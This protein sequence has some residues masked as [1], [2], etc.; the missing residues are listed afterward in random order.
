MTPC[1]LCPTKN[2]CVRPDGNPKSDLYFIGE[3]P[4]YDENKKGIPF[5]GKTGLEVHNTYLPC[6]GL[7][8][9][10]IYIDNAI[11]CLPDR[12]KGKLDMN[13]K[14]DRELAETCAAHHLYPALKWN[15]PKIIVPMGAFACYVI[16]PDI[17]LE[18]HH[19]IPVQTRFGTAFPMYHPAGGIHEPKK[20]LQIRTDWI[21]L[22]RFLAGQLEI[23]VDEH[24]DPDYKEATA[25]D[26]RGIDPTLPMGSDTESSR[27][28][29]PYCITYSQIPGVGRLIRAE[30]TLHLRMFQQKIKKWE[31]IVLFHNWLYDKA[32]TEDMGLSFPDHVIK[33]TMVRAFHLGNLPQGLKALAYRYLGMEMQAFEDLVKPHSTK[34]VLEYYRNAYAEE[35][36]KPDPEL[37]QDEKTGLWK[38]YQP[39]SMKTKLKRFFTDYTKNPNKNVFEMWTKNWVNSQKIIEDRMGLWPGM[40]IRHV[41]FSEALHYA[42]RDSDATLRLWPLL[43]RMKENVKGRQQENW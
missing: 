10:E 3:A 28:L 13:R 38:L 25:A 22:R 20:M 18:M 19:G 40:D 39:Q 24:P 30:N 12:P 16:D 42:C 17:D 33:D 36:P 31:S 8:R 4:G 7:S 37:N 9:P 26:I 23:P 29:G 34:L 5:V 11:S 15:R 27:R 41:P 32:V 6:A 35:W 21:R 2:T 1:A 14:Q 43:E